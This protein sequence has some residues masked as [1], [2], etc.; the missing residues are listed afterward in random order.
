MLSKMLEK[1]G[2]WN[3]CVKGSLTIRFPKKSGISNSYFYSID[4]NDLTA[5][6]AWV[7]APPFSIVDIS[8]KHQPYNRNKT[9]YI[10]DLIVTDDYKLGDFELRDIIAPAILSQVRG[11]YG[12]NDALIMENELAHIKQFVNF[13]KPQV[14]TISDVNLKYSPVAIGAP[15]AGLENLN[16]LLLNGIHPFDIYHKYVKPAM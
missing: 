16:G 11:M 1:E 14:V 3:Y 9:Q 4:N 10:P 2:I 7:V 6:H 5:G 12:N 13:F 8:I 15:D